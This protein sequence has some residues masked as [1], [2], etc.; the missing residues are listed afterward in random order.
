MLSLGADGMWVG[1]DDAGGGRDPIATAGKLMALAARHGL[2]GRRIAHTPPA[3][4]AKVDG[5]VVTGNYH[6]LARSEA[7]HKRFIGDVPEMGKALYYITCPPT[8]KR[9]EIA[10]R[11]GLA[12]GKYAWWHNW[13]RYPAGMLHTSYGGASLRPDK[14]PAYYGMVPITV[15]W[16][17]PRPVSLR[18]A[19]R[20]ISAVWLNACTGGKQVEYVQSVLGLWGWAPETYD[21]PKVQRA[22]Y[23]HVFGA[24]QADAARAFDASLVRLTRLM[25]KIGGRG[26]PAAAPRKADRPA[27]A[28]RVE[29]MDELLKAIEAAAPA[30]TMLQ[31]RR[32]TKLYL[33][34][35]RATVAFAAQAVEL[36]FPEVDRGSFEKRMLALLAAGKADEAA[37]ALA[38]TKAKV[39]PDVE[40]IGQA[41]GGVKDVDAYVAG[42]KARLSGMDYWHDALKRQRAEQA[43]KAAAEASRRARN[44]K[45]IPRQF[46]RLVRGDLGELLAKLTR[47]PPGEPLA[48]VKAADWSW[49]DDPPPCD[50]PWGIGLHEAKGAACVVIAYPEKTASRP[51][52]FAEARAELA[53]PPFRGRLILDAFVNDDRDIRTTG[54]WYAQLR[55]N[56]RNVWEEDIAASRAGREWLSIDVTDQAGP[57][58]K[59]KLRFRVAGK[60]GVSNYGL[61]AVLGAVRLRAAPAGADGRRN[62]E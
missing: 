49:K 59:L 37:R 50:G 23:G 10:R 30:E 51:G 17:R 60:R 33:E 1:Y 57:G 24:A 54:Y 6:G 48:E 4:P 36:T 45:D 28:A 43:R 29:Q 32:L 9:H 39:L 35:M 52:Y 16:G 13:P 38:E 3:S 22:V 41:L 19:A 25:R 8:D 62:P 27:A 34:P 12:E 42:W 58:A 20:Q 7:G 31:P 40:R 18:K 11:V 46:K 2:G 56:D 5:Q 44:I 53:V 26:A 55:V 47:P 14:A 61:T 15:G 21:W